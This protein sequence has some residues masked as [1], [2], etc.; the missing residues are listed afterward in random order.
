MSGSINVNHGSFGATPRVILEKQARLGADINSNREAFIW[1]GVHE[2]VT[3][4]RA[5]VAAFIGADTEDTVFVDNATE[6]FNTVIRSL[7][8]G[9]GDEVLLTD[10]IYANFPAPLAYLA[11]RQGFE[12]RTVAVP[13]PPQSPE[14]IKKSVLSAVT[15]KTKLAIID[16]ISS[17][18]AVIFP[19]KEIVAALNECGIDTFVDGAHAP[20]QVPLNMKD[21]GAAYYT[22]N[23]HKWLCA[24]WSSA[25][26]HVRKDRQEDIMPVVASGW[27]KPENPFA[28]RFA[29]QGTRD[30]TARLC[31][32]DT[33]SY[34]AS[35][36]PAGWPGIMKRNHDLA[37]RTRDFLCAELKMQK[38]CPEDMFGS[39]FTLPL[40]PLEFPEEKERPGNLYSIFEKKYDH[41]AYAAQ[42]NGQHMLRV[43]CHLYNDEK[44]YE[45]LPDVVCRMM[46]DHRSV[47]SNPSGAL[48]SRL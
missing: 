6:G 3:A 7:P 1:S 21:I 11:K 19:V 36:H 46:K 45:R 35:L 30:F 4:A 33:I 15:G 42:F 26:L 29:W 10:H 43:S 9:P 44:D 12:V 40:G 8:L 14:Q 18:T 38:P 37:V 39:M 23:H 28:E 13:Y 25:F 16:H 32:P 17:A 41:R 31:V 22:G 20:G 24:P 34:M 48:R 2:K 5:G 47:S 27:A